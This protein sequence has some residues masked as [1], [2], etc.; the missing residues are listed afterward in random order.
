M[1]HISDTHG[2]HRQITGLP[3]ADIIVILVIL[4]WLAQKRKRLTLSI[5]SVTCLI[6]KK[7][8]W[9]V[10]MTTVCMDPFYPA[11]MKTVITC[12]IRALA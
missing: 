1:I 3:D 11:L 2:R 7:S 10:I 8:L 6:D 9:P 12:V 4:P 5:G